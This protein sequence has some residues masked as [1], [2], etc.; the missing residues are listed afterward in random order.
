MGDLIAFPGVAP[1]VQLRIPTTRHA[2]DPP[3]FTRHM[4]LH[5]M[6]KSWTPCDSCETALAV[7]MVRTYDRDPPMQHAASAIWLVCDGCVPPG[8]MCVS[9]RPDGSALG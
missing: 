5:R 9:W 7:W 8:D 4:A 3:E 6:G 2:I 1:V